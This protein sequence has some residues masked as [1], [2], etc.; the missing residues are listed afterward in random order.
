MP[1]DIRNF[2]GIPLRGE[3]TRP[4]AAL[5]HKPSSNDSMENLEGLLS[6]IVRLSV[7]QMSQVPKIVVS[8]EKID[9]SAK[10]IAKPWS[11][12]ASEAAMSE[13]VLFSFLIHLAAAADDLEGMSACLLSSTSTSDSLGTAPPPAAPGGLVNWINPASGRSPLHVAAINGSTKCVNA[14]LE[15]GALVHLRDTLGHTSLY[16]VSA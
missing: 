16:Y 10:D 11:S 7:P 13:G 2:V 6:Q 3:L 5:P 1:S 4:S 9:T 8:S 15:A 14:L 12:T